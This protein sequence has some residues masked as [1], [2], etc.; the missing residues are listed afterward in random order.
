[1]SVSSKATGLRPGV[2]TSTTRPT[3]PYTG[4]IIYETDTGQMLVWNGSS[5]GSLNPTANRNVLINGNM[6]IAQRA[7]TAGS[8]TG[9]GYHTVDRWAFN[10]D[11]AG[12]WTMSQE[13]DA[14]PGFRKSAKVLCTVANTLA[15]GDNLTFLQ[16]IEGFNAQGFAKGTASA[17][18]FMLSFWVKSNV[19]G[20]YVV[21]LYDIDNTRQVSASYT[22]SSSG[23]WEYKTIQLPLDTTGQLDYDNNNSLQCTFWLTA[24][25]TFSSGTLNTSWASATNAN[26][27][28]GQVHLAAATN[29][30]WQVT[31]VQLE[32][33]TQASG[34]E[35]RSYGDELALCQRYYYRMSNSG[36]YTQFVYGFATSTSNMR[37]QVQYPVPMRAI[38]TALDSSAMSTFRVVDGTNAYNPTAFTISS[39]NSGPL[40]TGIDFN[41]GAVLVQFRPYWVDSN[42][43]TPNAGYIGISAEL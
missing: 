36:A 32:V 26:R 5:W 37:A 22:I 12:T 33:G 7:T 38:P 42:N 39:T 29:N 10:V 19:T 35:N 2:C 11:S 41:L 3:S 8:I 17:K 28:V 27:A 15:A 4:M 1:M 24:G 20:T 18:P 16:R 6:G 40:T 14:P 43:Q 25:S 9:A 30:Y 21:E 34:F 13:N 31:G 23:T